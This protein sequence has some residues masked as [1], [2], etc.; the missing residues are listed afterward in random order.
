MSNGGNNR[1]FRIPE[2]RPRSSQL[3]RLLDPT[4]H[5][6]TLETLTRAAHAVE[7]RV[8]LELV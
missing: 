1:S 6:V 3:N 8:K 7:R 2:R 5:S 4:T